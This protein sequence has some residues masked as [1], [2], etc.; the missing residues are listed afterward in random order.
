M[1]PSKV[2]KE[3]PA[4]TSDSDHGLDTTARYNMLPLTTLT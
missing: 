4:N 2:T 3:A 1:L